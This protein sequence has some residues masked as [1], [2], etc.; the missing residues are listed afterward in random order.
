MR[1]KL[2]RLLWVAPVAMILF[3]DA[4]SA[5]S[6][7]T[8]VGVV[9]D[10]AT[11]KPVAGALVIAT[12][13]ALQGEQT[14]VSDARGQFNITALPPGDYKLSAQLQ[15]FK[16][17][18]RAD[19]RLRV[20]FTLR[21]NLAMVPDSV[22][23]EE[24]VVRTGTA[25]AVNI[26][27]AEVGTIVSKDF[28][29]SVPLTSRS[30]ENAALIAPT[31]TRDPLGI[32][33]AGASSPENN[34]IIDGLR[35]ADPNTGQL[36][37]NL[38]TNFVDQLDVKVGSFMP[39]YGYSM[40]GVVN[41]VTKSGGNEFHGSIWGN[42]TPGFFS[43]ASLATGPNGYATGSQRAPYKGAY[44]S[45]FGLEVGGP[46]V[47]DKLWFYAGFAPQMN[48][49]TYQGYYRSRIPCSATNPA[50]A[51]TNCVGGWVQA[52]TG[53]YQ[54]TPIAGT[55]QVYGSGLNRYFGIAKLTWLINENHNA[56]VAFNTQ[57][58]QTFG[59][60]SFNVD[61]S[62]ASQK[63]NANTTNAT[64]NYTGK[65]LEKH[66]LLNVSGGW[67]NGNTTQTAQTIGGVVDTQ[68]PYISWRTA[69]PVS[70]FVSGVTCPTGGQCNVLNY[71]T[72][73][74]GY[75]EAPKT[76]RYAGTASLTGLFD[77]AGQHQLKGGAQIDY[78]TYSNSRYYSG[79][80][81]FLGYGPTTYNASQ[82]TNTSYYF[83][84]NR[85]YGA[86][87]GA[88]IP[89]TSRSRSFCAE[90]DAN[91]NC[92]NEGLKDPT[93]PRTLTTDT[94]TWT[95][96]FYLQDSWTIA[97]VLT[98]NFGVRLDMQ[99]MKASGAG[100]SPDA[101][102]L[103]LK[104]EWA[105]RVQAIWDF[106]GTG[107]GK[108]QANWGIY[109]EA[110]PLDMGLRAFSSEP[111]LSGRYLTGTCNNKIGADG[112]L[113]PGFSP[114]RDCPDSF[115]NNVG[116]GP[117]PNI[118]N[119]TTTSL[120]GFAATTGG[121]Y[122][123]VAPDLKGSYTQQY[124]GGIQYEVLQ[125][126]TLGVDYIGR[127]MGNVIEDMSNDDG[128]NY[129]I[130]NPTVSKPWT[131]AS[132]AIINPSF[133]LG[134]D[135]N[136]G[137][138]Y[139][140][141]VAK[142]IR[143]YDAVSVTLNKLFSKKWQALASY[144]W[145]SSRGNYPGLLRWENVQ[146]DPN[147]TSEY[148][149][150]AVQGNKFGPLNGN[151]TNQIKAAGSYAASLSSDVTLVPSGNISI[152]S[153]TPVSTV[154]AWPFYGSTEAFVLPRGS[155]GTLDWQWQV[156]LGAKMLW[157][158][159]GPYTLQ[160]SVDIFNILNMTTVQSVDQIYTF[161]YTTPMQAAQCANRNSYSSSGNVLK[162]L[163]ESCPDLPYARTFQYGRRV[164][165]NPNYAQPTTVALSAY[166]LPI[167]ARFGIAL[168]F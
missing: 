162:T 116:Q 102:V 50:P 42:L 161:D 4:A 1:K 80:A 114:F 117:G 35:V 63:T 127:A 123:P 120:K 38:L 84:V 154:A 136:T 74:W 109:Y 168:S 149:L 130:A 124:G 48:Y 36:G 21:A 10:A 13:K 151:R 133:G 59:R 70:N 6:N 112:F 8:I 45:D 118:T 68:A 75:V 91:G 140:I 164:T 145:S 72:G 158:I 61:A 40:A 28:L 51:G 132:G 106:T 143:N 87:Y 29:A 47:K 94:E 110:I 57:P 90:V 159:S 163:A 37:T 30:F 142:P 77:L 34:Y 16:P 76:N 98:L 137:V 44:D 46:I 131:T 148:D 122:S 33:F 134:T 135:Y 56:F 67:F 39:E 103:D 58:T 62:A 60:T 18:E 12:S 19:I 111:S 64:L 165:P 11:G 85:G 115:G 7:G 167:S 88:T 54:M 146:L 24:Q 119:L 126:L 104:N 66:L 73:G 160:F 125:D 138:A 129:T 79:G 82:P 52:P 71:G 15:G 49:M 147:I 55:D 139:A 97:N 31:A 101:P 69:Q 23:M 22:Q 107:R 20:D 83:G 141:N 86:Q 99:T 96:G 105:P 89:G 128:T 95:N 2:L 41:T 100:V 155:V 144:T 121:G 156:D 108:I 3:A 32:S 14:A 53:A 25:P 166:Q 93:N 27:S 152:F 153:G 81:I 92:I 43:P 65:F 113:V 78:S 157:A 26:G 150:V 17:A 9:S 5:Q